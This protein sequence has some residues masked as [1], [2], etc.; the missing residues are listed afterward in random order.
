MASQY[1]VIIIGGGPAGLSSAS[2]IV[3]QDHKTLLLDSQKYRNALSKHMYTVASWDHR[4]PE[5]FRAAS[6]ADLTRYGSVTIENA[7]VESLKQREDGLFQVVAGDGKT[8]TGKKIILATGVEDVFP[9]IPGYADCWVSGIFH[10]LYCHGWEEQWVNT[11]GMLAEGDTGAV[12]PALHFARQALRMAKQVTLYTNGNE[13]LAKELMDALNDAPAPMMVNSKK[14]TKLVKA[15]ERAR[16]VLELEDGT[17]AT[18]GFLAHKPKTK[19]RGNL[20]EQLGLEMT[21]MNT[22][23]VNPPFNQT[24]LKGVFAAGDCASPMQTVT[25]ALNG[26]TCTGGGAPLQIQAELYNQRAI[27]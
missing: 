13:A 18:E 6:R 7:E 10:C 4:D 1:D 8:W 5:E 14:I 3:R 22:V 12:V 2:S 17:A 11:A 20:A 21:P 16:V 15:P 25:G 23:K 9:D 26:G 19:L 24:S 27:F